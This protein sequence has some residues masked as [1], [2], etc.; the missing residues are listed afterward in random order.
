[1]VNLEKRLGD[2]RDLAPPP[3]TSPVPYAAMAKRIQRRRMTKLVMSLTAVGVLG[4]VAT[5]SVASVLDRPG[6]DTSP[7]VAI[8]SHGLD[9][10][11]CS[12]AEIDKITTHRSTPP[13][14]EVG[15]RHFGVL[16]NIDVAHDQ[17]C[18]ATLAVRLDDEFY[19]LATQPPGS[20]DART[21]EAQTRAVEAD[22]ACMEASD[23][24]GVFLRSG[25]HRID[26]TVACTPGEEPP[27]RIDAVV[28]FNGER[29]AEKY[30]R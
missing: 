16:L 1:M 13:S 5:G 29:F 25:S 3:E 2:L 21:Y 18:E 9:G 14:A 11:V 30:H 4:V 24:W 22:E 26:I 20:S 17:G 27:S 8:G 19:S 6:L 15:V 10:N 28:R 23:L 7:N 12:R